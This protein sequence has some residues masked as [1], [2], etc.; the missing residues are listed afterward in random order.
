[1]AV[2]ATMLAAAALMAAACAGSDP[3]R[4]T[5]EM[6]PAVAA[7]APLPVSHEVLFAPEMPPIRD[8][9]E[10]GL[11]PG[12]APVAPPIPVVAEP[13]GE[14]LDLP[15]IPV[16][17]GIRP[18]G[19]LAF[20]PDAAE[21]E[22]VREEEPA[23]GTVVTETV[24]YEQVPAPVEI[25]EVCYTDTV[26]VTGR[27][28]V[29]VGTPVIVVDGYTSRACGRFPV[30]CA[31][32]SFDPCR[33]PPRGAC[34]APVSYDPCWSPCYEPRCGW[35]DRYAP[36]AGPAPACGDGGDTV[37]VITGGDEGH[38]GRGSRAAHDSPSAAPA[39]RH[40]GGWAVAAD[41]RPARGPSAPAVHEPRVPDFRTSRDVLL[42]GRGDEGSST[43]RADRTEES[44]SQ[45]S[46]R[47]DFRTGSLVQPRISRPAQ[48]AAF[49]HPAADP[50]RDDVPDFRTRRQ[51]A[52]R[53]EKP[54]AAEPVRH[55]RPDRDG[56]REEEPAAAHRRAPRFDPRPEP[57]EERRPEPKA[58]HREEPRHRPH[59]DPKP[60]QEPVPHRRHK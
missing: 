4:P 1:M 9:G 57:Q 14:V 34:W 33:V 20:A 32:P 56:D 2:R 59:Y 24:V 16:P 36:C 37:I 48:T 25:V 42:G 27:E 55:A 47:P 3:D 23:A 39:P 15:P 19:V 26:T 43:P 8:P 44:G 40:R 7:A 22:P 13:A 11:P 21:E 50:V 31:S 6:S 18:A 52:A 51:P 60:D 53:E 17:P 35:R 29:F 28:T 46:D 10:S 38:E 54:A 58:E 45:A 12:E 30:V 49:R 5:P 41:P